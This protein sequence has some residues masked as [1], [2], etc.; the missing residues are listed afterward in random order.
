MERRK[1]EGIARN[2]VVHVPDD[3]RLEFVVGPLRRGQR[4]PVTVERAAAR[5]RGHGE[6]HVDLVRG[7]S[8]GA[9]VVVAGL[10]EGLAVV[11]GC[12]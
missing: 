5:L 12:G 4:G 3:V 8:E 7:A 11:I 9:D 1:L 6:G 10:S 2:A